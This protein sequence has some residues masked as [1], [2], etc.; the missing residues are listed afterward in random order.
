[1]AIYTPEVL[2]SRDS[3]QRFLSGDEAAAA[4]RPGQHNLAHRW[5]ATDFEVKEYCHWATTLFLTAVSYLL[6][7]LCLTSLSNR[8]WVLSRHEL[9]EARFAKAVRVFQDNLIT[10]SINAY[11]EEDAEFYSQ[12]PTSITASPEPRPLNFESFGLCRGMCYWY[13]HLF[14]K[15]QLRFVDPIEH[16]R[17]LGDLFAQGAP[18]QA[19]LLHALPTEDDFLYEMADL[20][21]EEGHAAIPT[22]DKRD[23]ALIAEINRLD[24]GKYYIYTS[25]HVVVFIKMANQQFI[26]DPSTGTIN[27]T[28]PLLFQNAMSCYFDLHDREKEIVIDRCMPRAR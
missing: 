10:R 28:S 27:V 2:S 7:G 20:D 4:L 13:M 21:V 5:D 25:N 26:F 14:F 12:I 17:A 18:I 16:L 3:F 6:Q 24:P 8:V 19:V 11:R 1:M 23:E 9:A 15:T 22:K